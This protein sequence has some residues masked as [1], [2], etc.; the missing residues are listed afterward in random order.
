[1]RTGFH[2]VART[3]FR[4]APN[5]DSALV[6][7]ERIP[8][9]AGRREHPPGRPRRVRA[10]AQDAR[11]LPRARRRREPRARSWRRSPRSTGGPDVARRGARAATSSSRS[12]PRSC[13]ERAARGGSAGEAE[14]R[15]RRRP[16]AARRQARGRHRARAA[17]ARGHGR[18]RAR[19]TRRP[20]TGFADDTLVGAALEAIC[21]AAGSP[22]RFAVRLTKRIP[23][24]AGL[25]GG[26][27]RR[28]GGARAR[29]PG[30][31]PRRA[32]GRARSTTSPPTL[33]AD[34]PVLPPR[35]ARSSRPATARRSSRS[36]CLATTA[37]C[38]C[39]REGDEKSSTRERLR[40]VRRARRRPRLRRPPC[41]RFTRAVARIRSSRDLAELPANDLASSP[42][43]AELRELGAFRADVSGAGPVVYG[44]FATDD[45]AQRAGE[46]LMGQARIW[47]TAPLGRC[48]VSPSPRSASRYRPVMLEES[49]LRTT[50]HGLVPT[51]EGW[52][53][54]NARDAPWYERD[55]RGFYCEFEGFDGGRL[56]RSSGSTSPC[57]GRA[58]RWRCTTG[59][60]IRRTSSWS[61]GE[62]LLVVEGEER[63]LRGWDLVH[64]P[65]GTEHVLVGA[66]ESPC[67]DRRRGCA[68]A[69]DGWRLGCLHG[70]R[71]CPA[72]TRPA[73]SGRPPTRPSRMPASPPRRGRGAR[74]TCFPTDP[75]ERARARMAAATVGV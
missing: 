57:C 51:G 44:L 54:L 29:E 16:A 67:V 6:A 11:E 5:V 72:V 4:P 64:C 60:P 36:S 52:F 31:R 43:A 13:A 49:K 22:R 24:A 63:P 23:V 65:P 9:P 19:P 45:E 55:G 68:R 3:V 26:L 58:S 56:L 66:G 8:A 30:A 17:R 53:V 1:M 62:A 59:K 33:G 75:P 50:E 46:A 42:L 41:R 37:S 27:E 40:G 34:V 28:G 70:V 25:G 47:V 7:F 38:S 14:P 20:S 10:P 32:R 18:A 39:C 15:A 73:S 61:R 71:R 48:T 21:A 69:L 35:P 12:Q 74:T 2:P